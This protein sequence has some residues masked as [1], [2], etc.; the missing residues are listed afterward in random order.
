MFR[1]GKIAEIKPRTLLKYMRTAHKR[2][3]SHISNPFDFHWLDV[4][5]MFVSSLLS[6]GHIISTF[7][8][9]SVLLSHRH[10]CSFRRTLIQYNRISPHF[11]YSPYLI[12][13]S[14]YSMNMMGITEA[15][16]KSNMNSPFRLVHS[17][18]ELRPVWN[19]II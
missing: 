1:N 13:I 14:T 2:T 5:D 3:K 17:I 18:N 19:I 10:F 8:W 15:N 9:I 7:Y 6:F 16:N 4:C 12:L 11:P